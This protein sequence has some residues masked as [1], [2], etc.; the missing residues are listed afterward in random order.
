[1]QRILQLEQH[2]A[3]LIAAGEVVQRPASVVKE[4]LENSIDAGASVITVEIAS[5]GMSYI[6]ITDDGHGISPEDVMTAFLRHATSKLRDAEG[7]EAIGTLGFRGEALA[8]I[9]AVSRIELHTR[10]QGSL[11]GVCIVLEGGEVRDIS[12]IGCPEGTTIIVRDLFYNTPARL[13]FMKTDRAEGSAVASVVLKAALSR[14]D[15]SVRFIKDGKTEYHT[16]GDSQVDS[17]IYSL[18][19]REIEAGFV[20]TELSDENIT[21]SGY[22]SKPNEARGNRGYQF[23]FVNGRSIRSLLL[24]TALENAYKNIIQSGRFPSCVLYITT[25]QANVDVNVHPAKTEV[26]FFSEKQIYDGVYYAVLGTLENFSST[27][28]IVGQARND[29]MPQGIATSLTETGQ[30]RNDGRLQ[31]VSTS[32]TE[33]GQARNDGMPQGIAGQVR[34]DG[35]PQGIATSLTETEQVC[36]DGRLQ[37]IAG[38]AR[39]DGIIRNDGEAQGVA[40]PTYKYHQTSLKSNQTNKLYTTPNNTNN[41]YIAPTK[42]VNSYDTQDENLNSQINVPPLEETL[43]FRIIGEA[44]NVYIIVEYQNIVFFIDKHAAHERIHYDA[45]RSGTHIPMSETLLTPIICHFG[46]EDT[47]LLLEN[48]EILDF[49]GFSAESFGED[50]IA[51]RHIPADINIADTEVLLSEICTLFKLGGTNEQANKDKIYKSMACKAAIKAGCLSNIKELEA[52]TERVLS[53]EVTHC[54]HGRPVFYEITKTTLDKG[55]GRM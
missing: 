17:C 16:P 43:Q 8:A 6:R 38:H 40:E 41:L 54:P 42:A 30:V 53:G 3:D 48:T 1:M 25:N 52:L 47:T 33:T 32:L 45:L 27:E 24:Q 4:L 35:M 10:V 39:N 13:K 14:P 44:F 37:G 15:V 55:F 31:G 21:V 29:G 12:S 18:F 46:N 36:N 34:N 28:G 11:E 2:I 22:I 19:G 23:F 49:L 50:S 5:G 26:K 20:A 9:A 51:I 7:L